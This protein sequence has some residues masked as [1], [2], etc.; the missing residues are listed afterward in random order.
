VFDSVKAWG[1]MVVRAGVIR[2]IFVIRHRS[3]K[4]DEL[5]RM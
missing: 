4:C 2:R 5:R 3:R 1:I